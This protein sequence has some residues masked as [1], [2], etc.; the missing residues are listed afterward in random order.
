MKKYLLSTLLVPALLMSLSTW[1]ANEGK[2]HYEVSSP[3]GKVKVAV[4]NSNT[5]KWSVTYDGRPSSCLPKSTSNYDRQTRPLV[6]VRL[7]R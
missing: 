3:N 5:I 7:V 6:L 4:T 2:A 1:A